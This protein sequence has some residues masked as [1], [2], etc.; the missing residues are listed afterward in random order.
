MEKLYLINTFDIDNNQND[1]KDDDKNDDDHKDDDD[2][3]EF[4]KKEIKKIELISNEKYKFKL[5]TKYNGVFNFS[6]MD[7][8]YLYNAKVWKKQIESTMSL[9]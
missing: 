7:K 1:H 5:H 4:G 3:M 2:E 6:L 9:T 8:Q